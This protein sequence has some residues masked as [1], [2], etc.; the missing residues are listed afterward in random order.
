MQSSDLDFYTTQE[1]VDALMRR[2]TFLGI[3]IHSEQE[4][5]GHDWHGER[6]FKVHFNANLD[7]AQAGRLL[8]SI[9]DQIDRQNA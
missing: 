6:M 3:V 5:K 4:L 2:K 9:A 8:D 1:L 7:T